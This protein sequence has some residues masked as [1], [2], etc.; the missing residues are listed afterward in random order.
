MKQYPAQHAYKTHYAQKEAALFDTSGFDKTAEDILLH[1]QDLVNQNQP[2][3]SKQRAKLPEHIRALSHSLTDEREDRHVSYLNNPV[4][5]SAYVRYFVWWN[6]VRLSRLFANLGGDFF[7]LP[8]GAS[9]LDIGSGPLTVPLALFIARPDLRT[10][11]LTWYC[12]DISSHALS[13]GNDLFLSALA[14]AQVEP[15]WNIV[16]VKGNFLTESAQFA[17]KMNLVT[18]ANVFNETLQ[19]GLYTE[20]DAAQKYAAL[21]RS[22]LK[23]E[24]GASLLAVEPGVPTCGHFISL[25]REALMQHGFFPVSPCTH[26]EQCALDG[27]KSKKWCNFAFRT[28]TAPKTLLKLSEYARLPKE[29][30]VLS[31]IAAK[32][33]PPLY[34]NQHEENDVIHARIASEKILLP[35]KRA[36]Y[37]ACSRL[38]LLLIETNE[39]LPNGALICIKTGAHTTPERDKKTGALVFHC[40]F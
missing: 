14:R 28:E 19:K 39:T 10:V 7:S 4:T 35:R 6:L 31:F 25:L 1:F 16:R 3:N 30:A 36:G 17:N 9:C 22:Y 40:V 21:L 12:M 34:K 15:R 27:K 37:Y 8:H 38:G 24:K 11:P 32:K 23:D 26:Y 5:L 29:R 18:C 20:E 13:V 33:M 2:L